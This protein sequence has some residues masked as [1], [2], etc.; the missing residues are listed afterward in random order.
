M[1]A[2]R[3]GQGPPKYYFLRSLGSF[4]VS[5]GGLSKLL[6][7]PITRDLALELVDDYPQISEYEARRPLGQH[8]L[9]QHVQT[10]LLEGIQT[11]T[12]PPVLWDE[13][14]QIFPGAILRSTA[15]GIPFILT[16]ADGLSLFRFFNTA[17]HTGLY[18]PLRLLE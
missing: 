9:L 2:F 7:D 11:D 16:S 5:F 10:F 6:F 3:V 14:A 15:K 13:I 4:P 18:P 12:Y 8:H 1:D 17:I